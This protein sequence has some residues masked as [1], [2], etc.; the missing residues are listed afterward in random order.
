MP[1]QTSSSYTKFLFILPP[2]IQQLRRRSI[3]K[4]FNPFAYESEKILNRKPSRF[5]LWLMCAA[6]LT[7]SYSDSRAGNN[8]ENTCSHIEI[9]YLNATH[10]STH[11]TAEWHHTTARSVFA[12]EYNKV[13]ACFCLWRRVLGTLS[14]VKAKVFRVHRGSKVESSLGTKS[15]MKNHCGGAT[16]VILPFLGFSKPP[17]LLSIFLTLVWLRW[18]YLPCK[19]RSSRWWRKYL[20]N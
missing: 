1:G 16:C 8:T 5:C 17:V 10:T 6:T 7:T 4:P 14:F 13:V 3:L 19:R 18:W 20:K 12:L 11:T 9:I 15:S 2:I